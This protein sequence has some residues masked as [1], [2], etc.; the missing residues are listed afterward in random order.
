MNDNKKER[1]KKLVEEEQKK[2]ESR[3]ETKSEPTTRIGLVANHQKV[4][5]RARPSMDAK[6]LQVAEMGDKFEILEEMPNWFKILW[7]D[8]P[9]IVGYISSSY[10]VEL[11][12]R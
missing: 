10:F 9:R 7:N 5:V 1:W 6:I 3:E 8:Y 11:N 2:T 4:N 12:K